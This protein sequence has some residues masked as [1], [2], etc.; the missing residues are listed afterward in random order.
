[1]AVELKFPD[2]TGETSCTR[3][4]TVVT[5]SGTKAV[6]GRTFAQ[7][8]ADTN[9][10]FDDGD[11]I[12]LRLAD[13]SGNWEVWYATYDNSASQLTRT[14]LKGQQGTLSTSGLTVF[15]VTPGTWNLDPTFNTLGIGTATPAFLLDAARS[16]NDSQRFRIVNANAG[17]SASSGLILGNDSGANGAALFL[18]SSA[19][20]NYGG[21]GSLNL[22]NVEA[23]ALTLGVDNQPDMYIDSGGN[24][25]IQDDTPNAQ[26]HVNQNEAAGAEPVL[27]LEQADVSEE[28]IEFACTIGAGN[29]IEAHVAQTFTVT[30]YIKVLL[31][32]GLVR[33]LQVGT[34][35]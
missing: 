14:D 6:G 12:G 23:A 35:T 10:D 1:M 27:R 17:A 9:I 11:K 8:M 30:H 15:A 28:M 24:V 7:A 22:I 4:A 34:L 18:G 5:L 2:A 25:G 29:G 33:Y 13:A 3:V 21:A 31:P 20:A 32:G 19:Y 26:L 16:A